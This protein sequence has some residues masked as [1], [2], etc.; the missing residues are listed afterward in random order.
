[1]KNKKKILLTLLIFISMNLFS[2]SKEGKNQESKNQNNQNELIIDENNEATKYFDVYDPWEN[3]NR[4]V[5]YFNY[6]FDTYFFSPVAKGYRLITPN[7]VEEGVSN[8][9]TNSINV[10]TMTNSLFQGKFRKFMRTLGRFSMN[11]LLGGLGIVDIASKLDMPSEYEDLGLTLAYYGVP[12]GPYLMLPILGP[13]NLR[14]A[15]GR[16]LDSQVTKIHPYTQSEVLDMSSKELLALNAVDTRKKLSFKYYETGTPF[17]YDYLRFF[18][19]E[20]RHFQEAT[21]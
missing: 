10:S 21:D 19:R 16:L 3:M 17:E 9:F 12:S 8:F 15:T 14:D 2:Y 6:Y 4:R 13:S 5:Y 1:M 7:I 11:T 20:F 18:Y